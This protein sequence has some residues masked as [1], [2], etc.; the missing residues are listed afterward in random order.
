MDIVAE[1]LSAGTLKAKEVTVGG[2]RIIDWFESKLSASVTF[3]GVFDRISDA[4]KKNGAVA[5]VGNKDYIYLESDDEWQEFGDEGQIGAITQAI[6]QIQD[7]LSVLDAL[8]G[9][10]S[11]DDFITEETDPVFREMSAS[12]LTSH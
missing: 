7:S 8:S 6:E 2:K 12:F 11:L 10:S 3:V 4:P 5:I 1:S 9:L